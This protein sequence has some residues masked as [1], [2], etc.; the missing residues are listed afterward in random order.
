MLALCGIVTAGRK[1]PQNLLLITM[2]VL[3]ACVF[4]LWLLGL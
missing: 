4:I 3:V 2:A 1:G